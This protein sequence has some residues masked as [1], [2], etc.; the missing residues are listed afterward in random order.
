LNSYRSTRCSP[1]SDVVSLHLLLTDE[2]K[3]FLSRERI[4]A[5]KPG[6]ILVNTARGALVDEEAMIEVCAR[7]IS[8]MPA[9]MSSRSSRCREAKS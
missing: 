4:A 5:M 3:G 8:V 9:S 7:A 1:K 2:T 6:V